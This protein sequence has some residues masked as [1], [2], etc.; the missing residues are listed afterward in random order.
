[1]TDR[2]HNAAG[3]VVAKRCSTCGIM[4][5]LDD[6]REYSGRSVDGHYG[7]CKNCHRAA[8]RRRQAARLARRK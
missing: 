6:F 1:M 4:Q 8:D 2:E 7:C 3:E 5:S